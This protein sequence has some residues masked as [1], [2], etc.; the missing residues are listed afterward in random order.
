[1]NEG[2]PLLPETKRKADKDRQE[3]DGDIEPGENGEREAGK[4]RDHDQDAE[5]DEQTFP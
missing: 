4:R 5:H 3:P 2:A 1:M